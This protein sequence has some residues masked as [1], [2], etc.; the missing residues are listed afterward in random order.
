[1]DSV[2]QAFAP[3]VSAPCTNGFSSELFIHVA[4][5]AGK[6]P[7]VTSFDV[8]EVN[9][10]YDRDEQTVKLAALAVWNFLAGLTLNCKIGR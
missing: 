5:L 7:R 2:D 9:P 4:Y 8:A 10:T 6:C 3:G 1:M